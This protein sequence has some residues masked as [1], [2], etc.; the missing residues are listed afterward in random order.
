MHFTLYE[1]ILIIII[2][3]IIFIYS[4]VSTELMSTLL[5]FMI[6]LILIIPLYQLIEE[7]HILLVEMDLQNAF[8]LKMIYNFSV[9]LSIFV[10]FFLFIELLYLFFNS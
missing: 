10:G 8:F 9:V 2:F 4:L 5:S 6:F 3:I 1:L 7:Y